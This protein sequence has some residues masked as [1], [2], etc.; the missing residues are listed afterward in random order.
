MKKVSVIILNWNGIDLLREY[1]PSVRQFTDPGIA[2]VIIADNG[3][4]D[5]SVDFV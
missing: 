3:S 2:D 5:G 4:D 1:L